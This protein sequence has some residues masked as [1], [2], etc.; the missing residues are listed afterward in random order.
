ME[1]F[2]K[3]TVLTK[4]QEINGKNWKLTKVTYSYG[5]ISYQIMIHLS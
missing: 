1:F 2:Y 4:K 3:N 5:N